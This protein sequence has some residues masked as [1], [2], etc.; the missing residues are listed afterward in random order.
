MRLL[1]TADTVGG[2][3]TFAKELAGGLLTLGCE[4]VLVSFGREPSPEQRNDA[5][6]LA[7]LGR[8]QFFPSTFPLE[9]M[10]E[11]A[12]AY[13]AAEPMLLRLCSDFQPHALLLSQFCFGALPVPTPKFVIAHS[14]VFS[15]SV[16]A[17]KAPLENDR[18]LRQYRELVQAGL[19]GADVLIAPTRATLIDVSMQLDLPAA[20]AVIPNGRSVQAATSVTNRHLWAVTAGRMWDPAK[21]LA[22]LDAVEFPM[23]ML[24]VGENGNAPAVATGLT[25]LGR[26]TGTE[27]LTLFRKSAI[28]ICCSLYEPF[29]LAPLEAA[30]CGCAVLAND[31]TTLHEVWGEGALYFHDAQTLSRLL[32]D[33]A[34]RPE[35]LHKA[36]QRSFA[37]AQQYSAE[38]M[39][40]SYL[41][42]TE[43]MV[44]NTQ[45]SSAR[46]A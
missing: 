21:N 35:L 8:F 24:V 4:V 45:G 46:A 17:G 18:W 36:Q 3:W 34:D 42:L 38:R 10:P 16:K 43:A 37:R 40:E 11:N 27:L 5:S 28:Y 23:P 15:W 41:Q 6:E 32:T 44:A 20:T 2:V 25:M 13:S 1:M 9:W 26:K 14:D 31:I 7:Q 33:L 22:L 29:G 30:L 19:A 39:A 12:E